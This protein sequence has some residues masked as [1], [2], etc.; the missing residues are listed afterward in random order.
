[1]LS[2]SNIETKKRKKEEN[3]C[4]RKQ[5]IVKVIETIDVISRRRKSIRQTGDIEKV[6][7]FHQR[8]VWSITRHR[9]DPP[10]LPSPPP[11]CRPPLLYRLYVKKPRC[12]HA[13]TTFNFSPQPRTTKFEVLS[14][15]S[16]ESLRS[17]AFGTRVLERKRKLYYFH[18]SR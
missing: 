6:Q 4:R 5:V 17:S 3:R 13:F 2:F 8:V 15:T 7:P 9:V 12:M 14:Q 11:P 18:N 10:P 1:M 16:R